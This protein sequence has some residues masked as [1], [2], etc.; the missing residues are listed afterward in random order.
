MIKKNVSWIMTYVGI[1]CIYINMGI[2][3]DEDNTRYLP[4]L[5]EEVQQSIQDTEVEE[6]LFIIED[7]VVPGGEVPTNVEVEGGLV[8]CYAMA[9]IVMGAGI[10][11]IAKEKE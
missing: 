8:V 5:I 11:G 7:E 2:A 4:D 1:L 6:K 10:R 9:I 3:L